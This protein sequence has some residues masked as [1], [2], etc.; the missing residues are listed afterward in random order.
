MRKRERSATPADSLEI[1]RSKRIEDRESVFVAAF[2]PTLPVKTLQGLDEFVTATH[3][4]A[5]WR[6]PSRQRSLRPESM[7]LYDLGH[8]DDGEKWAGSRLKSILEDMKV[9]GVI[10]VAR[11]YGGQ[12]IGPARFAHIENTAKE[13][14]RKWQSARE[15]LKT[16][17]AAKRRKVEQDAERQSLELILKERDSN[18]FALRGLLARK[19]AKLEDTEVAPLTPQ[20]PM[21][22]ASMSLETLKRQEK[23]RDAT[24]ASILH[25]INDVEDQM[26]KMDALEDA[27]DD[28]FDGIESK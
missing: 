18:I 19:K 24:I 14:V 16:E 2:S 23:A 28:L 1:F 5:A 25:R 22:Y 13:A 12:M 10:V 17:E 11:W 26:K 3:R 27:K 20:R 9:E 15:E 7:V 8:D 4:I 21:N 6:K